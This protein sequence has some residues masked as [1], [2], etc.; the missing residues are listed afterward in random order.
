MGND[1]ENHIMNFETVRD[2][3]VDTLSCNPEE[4]TLEASLQDDLGADSLSVVELMMAL[5]DNTGI[6]IDDET[7][8]KIK[9]VKDVMDCLDRLK[10]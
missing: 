5:E 4:V 2:I 9:T 1:K 7:A 8:A 6:S 10:G 3:L